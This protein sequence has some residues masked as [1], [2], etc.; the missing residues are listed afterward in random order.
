MG[1]FWRANPGQFSRVPKPYLAPYFAAKA[2]MD[3][4]AISY[5]GELARWNVETSMQSLWEPRITCTR[6]F[7]SRRWM[8]A[9]MFIARR[10]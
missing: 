8:R 6:E 2:G 7:V 10:H 5:A 9:N 1:Q 3:A 4:M